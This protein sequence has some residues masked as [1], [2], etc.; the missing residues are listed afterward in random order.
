LWDATERVLRAH[1]RFIAPLLSTGL[2]LASRGGLQ[3]VQ[4]LANHLFRDLTASS[5]IFG[6]Q[7]RP[8]VRVQSLEVRPSEATIRRG[9][10]R[11][12]GAVGTHIARSFDLKIRQR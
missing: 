8:P 2:G 3:Q 6:L 12:Q 11:K 7:T 9:L 1:R 4:P 10:W 5:L